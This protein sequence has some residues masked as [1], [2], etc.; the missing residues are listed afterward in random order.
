MRRVIHLLATIELEPDDDRTAD[1]VR[2]EI[3]RELSADT[4]DVVLLAHTKDDLEWPVDAVARQRVQDAAR[5][6]TRYLAAVITALMR[7]DPAVQPYL[8]PICPECGKVPEADDGI[9]VVLGTAVVIG[10]EGYWVINPNA[11]GIPRP[12]WQPQL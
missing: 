9:H 12:N 5:G 6:R 2:A 7:R 3:E 10:C 1:E 4:V 11:V 8:S